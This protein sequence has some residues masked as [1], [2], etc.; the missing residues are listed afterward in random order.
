MLPI[1][2]CEDNSAQRKRVKDSVELFIAR[3]NVDLKIDLVTENPFAVLK[4]L[5]KNK[6]YTGIYLLDVDLNE[7]LNGVNLASKIR[8][9]DPLGYIIFITS[10]SE[11]SY[12]TFRYKVEALDYI[13]K[14]NFEDLDKRLDQ[15]LKL[16]M[17]KYYVNTLKEEVLNISFEDR[18]INIP[19]NDIL[20]IETSPN[21]HKI[22]I[23]ESK[24]QTEVYGSL[25]DISE[26]LNDNFYRC[27][28]AYYLNTKK[29]A[30][31]DKK[32][33]TVTLTNGEVCFVSFRYMGGL[34]KCLN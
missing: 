31:I 30:N 12:L 14:D 9:K 23:H 18:I 27:H 3:E 22:I 16:C 2:I 10:H 4:H 1:I 8:E 21:P 26:K 25:K 29:I 28:R 33:R 7:D 20:F 32:L 6:D 11:L 24:K 15:C 5:E 17:K 34:L 13:I 19:L